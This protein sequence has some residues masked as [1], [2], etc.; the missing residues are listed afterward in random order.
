MPTPHLIDVPRAQKMFLEE[1]DY[2][3]EGRV[4]NLRTRFQKHSGGREMKVI[5]EIHQQF[6]RFFK[7]RI[8]F[9]HLLEEN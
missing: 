2:L 8:S 4:A 7:K 9:S 6:R 3:H 1:E 5:K